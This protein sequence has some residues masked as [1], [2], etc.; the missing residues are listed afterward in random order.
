MMKPR[1]RGAQAK[2]LVMMCF[3]FL[4]ACCGVCTKC[5][6]GAECA[7]TPSNAATRIKSAAGAPPPAADADHAITPSTTLPNGWRA[8]YPLFEGDYF[9][10]TLPISS[11]EDSDVET[12]PEISP[13]P[14]AG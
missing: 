11:A 1:I 13:G 9:S 2:H 4:S 3:V 10:V 14:P 5:P 6:A 12:E 8:S 7:I